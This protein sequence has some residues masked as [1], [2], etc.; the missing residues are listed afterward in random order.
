MSHLSRPALG[1]DKWDMW[2]YIAFS[3]QQQIESLSSFI[4][5]TYQ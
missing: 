3:G 1:W 5:E 4:V 2:Y